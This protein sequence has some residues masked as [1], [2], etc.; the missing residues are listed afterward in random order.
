VVARIDI[1]DGSDALEGEQGLVDLDAVRDRQ[2]AV[3]GELVP[4]LKHDDVA[5]RQFGRRN[6][7][8]LVVAAETSPADQRPLHCF[9]RP[10]CPVLLDEAD[11]GVDDD[12][13]QHHQRCPEFSRDHQRQ[14]GCAGQD[15]HV[16]ELAAETFPARN[17]D[18]VSQHVRPDPSASLLPSTSLSPL[19]STVLNASRTAGPGIRGGS[20]TA[21]GLW[22]ESVFV[23]FDPSDARELPAEGLSRPTCCGPLVA[24]R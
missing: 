22:T 4:G 23:M 11:H 2:S 12:H 21:A 5:R 9:R 1:L 17:A 6:G 14:K 7:V 20:T 3:D 16:A 15:Q 13:D 24:G 19:A 18:P 8:E 10:F